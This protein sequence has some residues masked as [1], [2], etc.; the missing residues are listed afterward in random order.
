M[1]IK[2]IFLKALASVVCISIV[3]SCQKMDKPALPADYPTDNP[4]TPTTPLRFY[5]S[6]DSTFVL[7]TAFLI[8]LL[9]FRRRPLIIQLE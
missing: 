5:L 1:K 7:R 4:V 6:F 9:S 2:D 8:I 3:S